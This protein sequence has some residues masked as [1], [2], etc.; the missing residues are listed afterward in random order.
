[1]ETATLNQ[2]IKKA[3]SNCKRL[4]DLMH[5]KNHIY[6]GWIKEAW[7]LEAI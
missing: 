7:F 6:H 2:T 1:M 4:K 5:L 3:I